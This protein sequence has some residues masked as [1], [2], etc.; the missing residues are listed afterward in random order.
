M[1]DYID[2]NRKYKDIILGKL[3]PNMYYEFKEYIADLVDDLLDAEAIV[4]DDLDKFVDFSMAY[5]LARRS[6]DK[7]M[8]EQDDAKV[9]GDIVASY[10]KF[11]EQNGIKRGVDLSKFVNTKKGQEKDERSK[12]ESESIKY[13]SA[14]LKRFEGVLADNTNYKALTRDV[15]E[16]LL[17]DGYKDNEIVSGKANREI[18]NYIRNR[19]FELQYS[20]EFDALFK[21]CK[22]K[23]NEVFRE[24]EK[25]SNLTP[26]ESNY[27]SAYKSLSEMAFR[28]ALSLTM[29]NVSLE[30]A[31]KTDKMYEFIDRNIQAEISRIQSVRKNELKQIRK[32]TKVIDF[33]EAKKDF[34]KKAV[35]FAIAFGIFAADNIVYNWIHND[36]KENNNKTN[37]TPTT[38]ST[39][40]E[41]IPGSYLD[42]ID[43]ESITRASTGK[44]LDETLSGGRGK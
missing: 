38:Y 28:V 8:A 29:Q 23:T 3:E 18:V 41:Y 39:N 16:S 9:L 24:N 2:F 34:K 19:Y 13:I 7:I 27:Y 21:F 20:K 11:N 14:Y 12:F 10:V 33:S 35:A 37:K 42:N 4:L 26:V 40:G 30:E 25:D 17:F 15:Y 43:W 22:E 1:N 5:L 44:T 36:K 31:K 32:Q 6:A